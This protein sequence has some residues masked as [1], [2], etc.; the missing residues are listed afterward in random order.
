MNSKIIKLIITLGEIKK[1]ECNENIDTHIIIR[2]TQL[3]FS[4]LFCGMIT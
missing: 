1:N 2:G 4:K 3:A